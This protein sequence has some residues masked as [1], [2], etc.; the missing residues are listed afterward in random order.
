MDPTIMVVRSPGV[1]R[2]ATKGRKTR[3]KTMAQQGSKAMEQR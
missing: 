1:S 3:I 2:T